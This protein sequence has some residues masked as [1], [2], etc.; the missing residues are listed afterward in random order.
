M[1]TDEPDTSKRPRGMAG[2]ATT[3]A[4][5]TDALARRS[6]E[7]D[8]ES[9]PPPSD[10]PPGIEA[11]TT[12][13]RSA[14]RGATGKG[15]R[16]PAPS[17]SKSHNDAVHPVQIQKQSAPDTRQFAGAQGRLDAAGEPVVKWTLEVAPQLVRAL[18]VWERDE[19]KR[20][21][22]RVY[23]ERVI[24]EALDRLPQD[25]D[26][27]LDVVN[28]MP[29]SLRHATGEQLGTR[30]RASVRAKLIALR[31]ELRVAGVKNVKIR[32]IYS[33][34]VYQY[35]IALGVEVPEASRE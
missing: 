6:T 32:D 22:E 21:G 25:I 35:L 29:A 10:G 12:K 4:G 17:G 34:G 28:G 33:A 15:Q 27:I 23:R 9:D 31:P 3:L 30:V 14:K 16:H 1:T 7:D 5:R 11:S 19:T 18:S 20:L 8:I 24:D 26:G 13:A 2:L